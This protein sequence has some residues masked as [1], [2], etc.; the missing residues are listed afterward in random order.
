MSRDTMKY[1][2]SSAPSS[3][4]NVFTRCLRQSR[5]IFALETRL[6][7]VCCVGLFVLLFFFFFYYF[8]FY[9]KEPSVLLSRCLMRMNRLFATKGFVDLLFVPYWIILVWLFAGLECRVIVR[10]LLLWYNIYFI[11]ILWNIYSQIYVGIF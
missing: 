1:W 6:C 9:F 10:F 3:P 7:E 11:D 4:R 5:I 8:F 2:R